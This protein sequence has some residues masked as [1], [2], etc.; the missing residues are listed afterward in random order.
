VEIQDGRASLTVANVEKAKTAQG[1]IASCDEQISVL[2]HVVSGLDKMGVGS[3]EKC[4]TEQTTAQ[5]A[6]IN[7]QAR[8]SAVGDQPK[9]VAGQ[10]LRYKTNERYAEE[11]ERKKAAAEREVANA[12]AA[13]TATTSIREAVATLLREAGIVV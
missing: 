11:W 3:W 13:V 10:D 1:V 7:A 8:L 12:Q 6:V 2:E 5:V 4:V 9:V